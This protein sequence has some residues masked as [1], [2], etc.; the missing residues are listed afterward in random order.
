MTY[1]L[2]ES[3]SSLHT[4]ELLIDNLNKEI[5]YF[6]KVINDAPKGNLV[7]RTTPSGNYRYAVRDF[8][9]EEISESSISIEGISEEENSEDMISEDIT[10][11]SDAPKKEKTERP[12]PKENIELAKELALREY[13]KRRVADAKTQV[14][15]LKAQMRMRTGS[16]AADEYLINH[17]G[18]AVLIEPMIRKRCGQL[19]EWKNAPYRRS[20]DFPEDLI[21]P[22]IVPGLI[23]RSKAE[24]DILSRF[25]YFG[26]PYHYEEELRNG[27][28]VIYPDFTCRNIRTGETF[29]WEHQG[30][31]DDEGY[32]TRRVNKRN[33]VYCRMGIYPGVN[34]IV[35]TE[36]E[37]HPLDLQW[38][39]QLISYYLL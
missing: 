37:H 22:T 24:A 1:L 8:F 10:S 35:S 2:F 7:C 39:D 9:E 15:G 38:V 12:I 28:E 14:N 18:A 19:E 30:K 34:L 31:W 16:R 21:Y 13:A 4:I 27:F 11:E 20:R 25:E 36:T 32:V 26:V 17:P 33:E 3:M 5:A 29:Y 23:V 6:Q